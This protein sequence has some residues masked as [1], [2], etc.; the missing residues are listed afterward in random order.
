MS[1]QTV[2]EARAAV[3]YVIVLLPNVVDCSPTQLEP[4]TRAGKS[5]SKLT[6]PSS[7]SYWSLRSNPTDMGQRRNP[8]QESSTV[9]GQE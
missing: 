4:T 9:N 1:L 8:Q 5:G 6:A 7:L 2:K 3:V